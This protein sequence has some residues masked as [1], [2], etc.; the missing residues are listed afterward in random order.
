MSRTLGYPVVCSNE[1]AA[2]VGFKGG[3]VDLGAQPIMGQHDAHV[4]GW[5]PP[6]VGRLEK[7]LP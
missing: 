1:I 6:L 4:W 3:L 7:G 2:A 5:N